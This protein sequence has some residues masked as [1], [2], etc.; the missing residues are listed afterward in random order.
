MN[1]ST[2]QDDGPQNQIIDHDLILSK[3][4][5]QLKPISFGKKVALEDDDKLKKQ[6]FI[7]E[8]IEE[9]KN[10]AK[11]LNWFIGVKDGLIYVFNG[12]F[13][14]PLKKTEIERFLGDSA[15]KLG[16]DKYD[17]KFYSFRAELV[18]QLTSSANYLKQS[19]AIDD[20]L[21]NL[22]NGTFL[23]SP[24][25]TMFSPGFEALDFLTYQLP[26]E[27]DP[28]AGCPQFIQFLDEVL[29]DRDLQNILAEYIGYV[30]F[31]H[32]TLKLE[33]CMILYGKGAN[34]KSVF[35]DVINA[36]L[37][38][39]NVSSFSLQSLTDNTGYFRA[40]IGNKL[41]NYTSE[42][43]SHMDS[44]Y[45]KQLVSGE[46]VDGRLPY[47]NPFILEDYAKLIFNANELPRDVE[48]NEAFF[49]RFIIIKFD[50]TIPEE[51]RDPDL[52]QKIISKELS[53]V[54]NWVL[55]GLVRLSHQKCFSTSRLAIEA[56]KEYKF[57]SCSVNLF[58]QDE[59]YEQSNSEEI[60]LHSFYLKY[61]K[62][63]SESGYKP[64]SKRVFAER[65]RT[66]GYRIV[67]RNTGNV[68]YAQKRVS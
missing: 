14:K 42:I 52:A 61:N 32:R 10:Q 28:D 20:V 30:F 56:V 11:E 45:F 18:K 40:L 8:T 64:T 31:R 25:L 48:Q 38:S 22:K 43:S 16:V 5:E 17:A 49:R 4:I 41:L 34:G 26:F 37:G 46:P 1:I 3:I 55:D 9:V 21:I 15:E 6:H 65:L 50:V 7:I 57:N 35:F 47:G 58:L 19:V 44:A 51:R 68:V 39:E 67:R 36:L 33:K 23:H 59:L 54:F 2:G 27:F 62:H 66:L 60:K 53:G 29:P 13:W 63:S 12:A 24:E